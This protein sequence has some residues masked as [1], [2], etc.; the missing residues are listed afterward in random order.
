M[1]CNVYVMVLFLLNLGKVCISY[2]VKRSHARLLYRS[3]AF[4]FVSR[5]WYDVCYDVASFPRKERR[6]RRKKN[7]AFEKSR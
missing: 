5:L 2:G 7:N 6:R 3:A 1:H 4:M